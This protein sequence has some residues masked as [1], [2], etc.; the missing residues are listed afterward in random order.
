MKMLAHFHRG[1]PEAA[2]RIGAIVALGC[3]IAVAVIAALHPGRYWLAFVFI[4][5]VLALYVL[6][7]R[8]LR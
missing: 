2:Q 6:R 8:R 3:G 7:A 5:I 1:V 4:G